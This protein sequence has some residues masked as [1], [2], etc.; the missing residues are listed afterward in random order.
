MASER[1][2]RLLRKEIR[3]QERKNQKMMRLIARAKAREEVLM[4]K[5]RN[6]QNSFSKHVFMLVYWLI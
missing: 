1:E 4:V 5:N 6:T 2:L 3:S